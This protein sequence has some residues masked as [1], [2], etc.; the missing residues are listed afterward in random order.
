MRFPIGEMTVGDILDRGI[1]L[2][3]ARLPVYYAINI[4]VLS[5]YILFQIAIPFIVQ[6]DPGNPATLPAI[7]ALSLGALVVL[8]I[9]QP[10]GMAAVLYIIMEEYAGRHVSIG[11]AL[12]FGCSR[13]PTLL[14][15]SILFGLMFIIGWIL[16]CIPGIYLGITY[17]FFGQAV[18]LERM[19][20]SE[21]FSRSQSLVTGHRWRVFGV[22]VLVYIG[23][24]IVTL[25]VQLGLLAALPTQELVPMEE[26]IKVEF[27][28]VN[29]IVDTLVT[30]LVSILFS[31]YLAVC[32]TLLY[33]DLRI[34]KE[35]FDLELAAEG[36]GPRPDGNGDDF[37]DDE[38]DD[39]ERYREDRLR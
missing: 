16:C 15:A 34:R 35:G 33:L 11:Q 19:N 12:A 24:I 7:L 25:G 26:G 1:K 3:F 8:V 38:G 4:L 36:E 18:V 17:I 39:R 28:P 6:G 37:D 5:P 31:T 14:G 27:N 21:S 30:Q 29:H 20:V 32:V 23:M 22:V 13:F 10:I 9:L 2:L